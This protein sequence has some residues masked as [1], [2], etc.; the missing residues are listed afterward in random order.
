MNII[1]FRRDENLDVAVPVREQLFEA[2]GRD[3]FE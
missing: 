2:L 3:V 1:P